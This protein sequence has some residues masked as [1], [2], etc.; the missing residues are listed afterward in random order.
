MNKFEYFNLAQQMDYWCNQ[1]YN[2]NNT[3]ISDKEYDE[4]FKL[5]EEYEDQNPEDIVSYS[6]TQRVG[7]ATNSGFQKVTRKEKMYSLDNS[8]SEEE[9]TSFI[10]RV[11]TQHGQ[12]EFVVEPKIDGTSIEI[13]YKEGVFSRA[14]TRGDGW[15]GEDI[16]D[17]VKTIKALPLTIPWKEELVVRGE[18]YID[19]ADLEKI[20]EVR[21]KNGEQP[22][23]NPRNAASGSLR[24][25]NPSEVAKRPLKIFLFAMVKGPVLITNQSLFLEWLPRQ[26]LPVN[27]MFS[28]CNTLRY[29]LDQVMVIDKKRR[30]L[31]Y[32]IDGAVIKVND[33][34]IQEEEGYTSRAPKWAVAYKF[35][36]EKAETFVHDIT[37][38]VGR[39]GALTPVAELHPVE[40]SGSVVSRASL[41]N[42]DIIRDLDI[43]IGDT[44]IVEKAAEI[45]PQ[46]VAV[47]SHQDG[48]QPFVFPN[49]CPE[50]GSP[51]KRNPEEAR[52][53]CTNSW[54]CN[55]QTLA[56]IEHFVHRKNMNIDALGPAI[57]E[58]LVDAGLIKNVSDL[59]TLEVDDFLKL[60]R[61]GMSMA[62]KLYNNIQNSK[63][64][65]FDRM[66]SGLGIPLIGNTVSK[67]IV[68]K[69]PTLYDLSMALLDDEKAVE[70]ELYK[71]E[72]VGYKAVESL[73]NMFRVTPFIEAVDGLINE[74]VGQKQ[75]VFMGTGGILT[76]KSFCVT[77]KLSKSRDSIW[78][79][80][81]LQGGDVHK[82]VKKATTY[83]VAGENVGRTKTD[84][85]V[86][87]GAKVISEQDLY[88]M[89]SK[90]SN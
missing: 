76:G 31:P 4:K 25:L 14:L 29:V 57:I 17:N 64:Q 82:S 89:L 41:H 62:T 49:V 88:D 27:E 86:K 2:F 55:A 36:T 6:P 71:I 77:G 83:L 70:K 80:I 73:V 12:Q 79:L 85:A 20:N 75:T 30:K 7:I 90:G 42:E 13:T 43:R 74:G 39:T 40:I 15:T 16:T 22:F 60:D 35:E 11:L 59:Y 45:I 66:L 10:D 37:I 33:F 28:K 3:V 84:K 34:E 61:M 47:K 23:A 65:V 87:Y 24:L 44:V 53:F 8:Y 69:Y 5:L 78:E 51:T 81:E 21:I 56:R 67:K 32:E 54:G 72:G 38:Q 68:K 9:I 48:S 19:K 52:T 26:G 63:E 18:V 50:C 1:Y 58:Q 46:V